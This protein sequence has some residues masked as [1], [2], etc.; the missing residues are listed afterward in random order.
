[1]GNHQRFF[2]NKYMYSQP[3]GR[4]VPKCEVA[5][6]SDSHEAPIKTQTLSPHLACRIKIP[7]GEL[8]NPTLVYKMS[9]K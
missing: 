5:E 9:E 8:Y 2:K 4:D 3:R 7:R 6:P 1:M